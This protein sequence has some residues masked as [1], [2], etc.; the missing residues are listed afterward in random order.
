MASDY[1]LRCVD[2]CEIPVHVR[3]EYGQ[4]IVQHGER[5]EARRAFTPLPEL[6]STLPPEAQV[7]EP[8]NWLRMVH[9]YESGSGS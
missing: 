9:R 5:P 6:P 2:G 3:W 1:D 7:P 8:V 4:V